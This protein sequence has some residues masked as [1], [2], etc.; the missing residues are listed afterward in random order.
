MQP[1]DR[2]PEDDHVEGVAQERFPVLD[3]V[4]IVEKLSAEDRRA[5]IRAGMLTFHPQGIHH[6]PQ[7]AAVAA[8]ADK[9]RTNEVAVMIDTRHP[10]ALSE[11]GHSI[12][13]PDYWK[14]WSAK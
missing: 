12:S 3:T 4:R 2:I 10:L 6:G 11:T 5:G 9:L 1:G 14:S 7:P 13:D 8:S